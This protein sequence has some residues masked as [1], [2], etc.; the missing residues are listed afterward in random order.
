MLD[1]ESIEIWRVTLE[2]SPEDRALDATFYSARQIAAWRAM[3]SP[4]EQARADAFH[5]EAHCR[6]YIVAH[7][8]LRWVLGSQLGVPPAAVDFADGSFGG[9][10]KGG[11]AGRIKPALR[12]SVTDATTF[13]RDDEPTPNSKDLRFNLSHTRGAALI[14]VAPGR[15]LGIDIERE[16]PMADLESIARSVMSLEEWSG[17]MAIPA[18][19]Q[20]RAFYRLWT[21]KEAYLKG[22]GLGLYRNL[23]EVTVPVTEASFAEGQIYPVYDRAGTEVWQVM[24]I[25]AGP[26]FAAALALHSAGKG[27]GVG[28]ARTVVRHLDFGELQP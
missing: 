26:G 5:R 16:R 27:A 10:L 3:L 1:S 18:E 25:Q 14:G 13:G 20:Q 2:D 15:E 17:W 11:V 19:H 9:S 23:Q 12:S 6:D 24:D 28:A 7:A 22:I 4:E 21:R 8:A